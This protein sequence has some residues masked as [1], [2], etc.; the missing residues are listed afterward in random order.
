MQRL[1]Y[2]WSIRRLA[3]FFVIVADLMKVVLV[4]LSD[5]TGE[6]AVFKMLWQNVLCKFLVL[7]FGQREK[8]I[9]T[10]LPSTHLEDYKTVALVTPPNYAFIL[11]TFQHSAPLLEI[12]AVTDHESDRSLLVQLANL[13]MALIPRPHKTLNTTHKVARV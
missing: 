12:T 5:K 13:Y 11:R 2:A 6:V 1:T 3:T 9:L 10:V 4:Q 7:T 8:S